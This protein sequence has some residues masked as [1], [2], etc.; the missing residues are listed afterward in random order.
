MTRLILKGPLI[1]ASYNK[2]KIQE[3]EN[4]FI[5]YAINIIP[6]EKFGLAESAETGKTF[7][8]NAKA[9]ALE[10]AT[11]V[12]LPAVA[13]D[14]GLVVTALGGGPGLYSARWAREERSFTAAMVRIHTLLGDTKDRSARFVS[15][16][17]LAWPD[18]H[19]ETFEGV[20]QGNIVWPPRG[21]NGFGYDPI[22]QPSG[23][24]ATFA[25]MYP[26]LKQTISH[27]TRAFDKLAAACLRLPET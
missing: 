18:G 17:A 22:F 7:V 14:S 2:G 6:V 27:R 21:S 16:L 23:H 1:V 20:V 25:E 3:I 19:T 4:L 26:T 24:T 13:D 9:K 10:T 5:K 11:T 8:D 12:G 15:A